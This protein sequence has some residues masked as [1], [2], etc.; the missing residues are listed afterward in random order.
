MSNINTIDLS[1][2]SKQYAARDLPGERTLKYRDIGQQGPE[3][4]K[5]DRKE[6]RRDLEE[7]EQLSKKKDSVTKR[8]GIM[9]KEGERKDV[10]SSKKQK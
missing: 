1:G 2:I 4:I 6:L 3:E 7:R 9:D 10:S 5:R 8:L